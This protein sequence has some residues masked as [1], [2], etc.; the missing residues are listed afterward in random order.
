[1]KRN[2]NIQVGDLVTNGSRDENY[3][4]ICTEYQL[5]LAKE[6][7]YYKIEKQEDMIYHKRWSF[8][9]HLYG[10]VVSS[11]KYFKKRKKV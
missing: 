6:R 8:W 3:I 7:G 11:V 5:G 9:W 2:F 1:M 10:W 4:S